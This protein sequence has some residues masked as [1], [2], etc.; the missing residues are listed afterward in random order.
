MAVADL[1][2][3]PG[4]AAR[5]SKIAVLLRGPPGSGKSAAAR[6]LFTIRKARPAQRYNQS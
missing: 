6:T 1:L 4:R 2:E 3:Q 5:A